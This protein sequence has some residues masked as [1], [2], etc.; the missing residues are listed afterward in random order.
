MDY[1]NYLKKNIFLPYL[2]NEIE[3]TSPAAKERKRRFSAIHGAM[4][5]R[6]LEDNVIYPNESEW[7]Q[8]FDKTGEKVLGIKESDFYKKDYIGFKALNDAG[9]VKYVALHG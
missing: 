2:N 6:F 3:Q 9:K 7:F 1:D 5:V 4:L 8:S